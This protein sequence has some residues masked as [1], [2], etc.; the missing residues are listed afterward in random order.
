MLEWD[1][2]MASSK[3]TSTSAEEHNRTQVLCS[4]LHWPQPIFSHWQLRDGRHQEAWKEKKAGETCKAACHGKGWKNGSVV[5][6]ESKIVAFFPILC[7]FSWC[8]PFFPCFLFLE[9]QVW[10]YKGQAALIN[11]PCYICTCWQWSFKGPMCLL[12]VYPNQIPSGLKAGS[13]KGPKPAATQGPAEHSRAPEKT[14]CLKGIVSQT[15]KQFLPEATRGTVWLWKVCPQPDTDVFCLQR[16]DLNASSRTD[17][18]GL[19]K[20]YH[21]HNGSFPYAVTKAH[22]RCSLARF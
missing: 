20:I 8:S 12:C 6:G 2:V 16:N 22:N 9:C 17:V 4:P 5:L 15:R 18:T 21:T 19:A 13:K 3:N 11:P 10:T 1:S 7:L 14:P